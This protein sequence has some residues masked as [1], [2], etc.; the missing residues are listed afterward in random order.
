MLIRV[1][2]LAPPYL[3]KAFF[4]LAVVQEKQGKGE[5]SLQNLKKALEAN[6]AN[7]KARELL[8]RATLGHS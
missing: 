3:D 5:E 2:E 4:N 1:I 8:V 7:Q 6:P